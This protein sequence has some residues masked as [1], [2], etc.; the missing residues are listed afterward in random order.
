MSLYDK[1][2]MESKKKIFLID[3]LK[4]YFISVSAVCVILVLLILVSVIIVFYH[5]L[6]RN[7]LEFWEGLN[8]NISYNY[9]TK[10]FYYLKPILGVCIECVAIIFHMKLS[11]Y[12]LCSCITVD[13]FLSY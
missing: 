1:C 4:N 5:S 6:K 10:V 9:D 7:M 2:Y 11:Y 3:F 8:E 12:I 13:F